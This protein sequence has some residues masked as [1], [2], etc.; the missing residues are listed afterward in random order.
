MLEEPRAYFEAEGRLLSSGG[1]TRHELAV[2]IQRRE[3]A[4]VEIPQ[5][6]REALLHL[7]GMANW[8]AR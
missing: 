4:G 7:G 5:A 2:E 6:F 1:W 3:A 8:S